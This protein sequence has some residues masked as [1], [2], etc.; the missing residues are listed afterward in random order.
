MKT[1]EITIGGLLAAL[2]LIIPLAFGGVLG[3]VIPPFSATL[4]SH[5]PVM[6]AMLISPA[7]A[8]FVGVVSAIGFLIK[9]GP[10][11]AARAAVHAVFGYVGAKMIQRG[12]S[13]P[14]ALAVTLP[15]HA[16]LEA[17]VVMPFGFD[18]Y[19]SFVVVGVGTMIHHTID[20]AIALALFY[21]LN[22]ILKFK[23]VD[24]KN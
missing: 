17:I 16:V 11:I 3:I 20:S 8:V 13:F 4:A 6:L 22:P 18:F 19:K 7:T 24:I 15:I 10:I 12:Y 9:L 14:V 5:V 21:A 1:R 23:A 2:S